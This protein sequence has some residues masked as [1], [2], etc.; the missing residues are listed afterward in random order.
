MK[1]IITQAI[2]KMTPKIE[3]MI[4]GAGRVQALFEQILNLLF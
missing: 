4:I 3:M 1:L 2:I